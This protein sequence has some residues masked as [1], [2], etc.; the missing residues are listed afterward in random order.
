L[1]PSIF[2][3]TQEVQQNQSLHR[4]GAAAAELSDARHRA[5]GLD[6]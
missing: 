3:V 2:G 5:R 4:I 6:R 1:R